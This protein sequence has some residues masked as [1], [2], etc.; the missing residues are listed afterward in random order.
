MVFDSQ[1]YLAWEALQEHKHE[2]IKGEVF[3]IGGVPRE[4][5]VRLNVAAFNC[6]SI[7]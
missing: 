7:V 6:R 5:V 2:F 1:D 4:H 3:A